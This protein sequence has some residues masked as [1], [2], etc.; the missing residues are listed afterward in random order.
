M[1]ELI[2]RKENVLVPEAPEVTLFN[3]GFNASMDPFNKN[4]LEGGIATTTLSSSWLYKKCHSCDHSFRLDDTVLIAENGQIYHDTELLRCF[5][6]D[7]KREEIEYD[8]IYDFYN[9]ILETYRPREGFSASILSA[10]N[11]VISHLLAPA[12]HGFQRYHCGICTHTLRQNDIIVLCPC[13]PENPQCRMAI[14][15]DPFRGLNCWGEWS[16]RKAE[17]YCPAFSQRVKNG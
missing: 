17:K 7:E 9:G 8:E 3:S 10:E 6:Q 14:H 4:K 5:G 12:A 16:S 2:D 1:E 11:P 15:W 13:H